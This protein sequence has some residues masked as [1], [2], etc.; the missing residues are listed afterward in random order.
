MKLRGA[1]LSGLLVSLSFGAPA[2]AEELKRPA[3]TFVLG[4]EDGDAPTATDLEKD[5]RI[6]CEIYRERLAGL[7]APCSISPAANTIQVRV[8]TDDPALL[9]RVRSELT[10]TGRLELRRV[11]PDSPI[12]STDR[13]KFPVP[14]GFELLTLRTRREDHDFEEVLWVKRAS[15]LAARSVD[16]AAEAK[17][18]TGGYEVTV[19]FIESAAARFAA[20]TKELA[21]PDDR[22]PSRLAIVVDGELFAAPT[23]MAPITGGSAVITGSFDY[24]EALELANK[25]NNPW[26][27]PFLLD[28]RT[29]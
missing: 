24:R 12:D 1:F 18:P 17:T 23:V 6:S 27:A 9:A 22:R 11:H 28:V 19:T 25:L 21:E 26:H 2:P 15:E 3:T 14:A 8:A 4:F 29:D 5:I 20:L 13:D 16:H 10:R 7:A